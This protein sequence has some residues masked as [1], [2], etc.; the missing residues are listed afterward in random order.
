M[1]LNTIAIMSPGEMGH[2][3]GQTLG[4]HGYDVITWT[5]GNKARVF[6]S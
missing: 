1:A 3:V 2:G 4:Q 6:L 5:W